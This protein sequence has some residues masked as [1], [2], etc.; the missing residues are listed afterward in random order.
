MPHEDHAVIEGQ[1]D[2]RGA[3]LQAVQHAT[4]IDNNT[5]VSVKPVRFDLCRP[6]L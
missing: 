5:G 4:D 2:K 6:N 3:I 1:G